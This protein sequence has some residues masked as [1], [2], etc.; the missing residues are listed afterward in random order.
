VLVGFLAARQAGDDGQENLRVVTQQAVPNFQIRPRANAA[1]VMVSLG[2]FS[3]WCRRTR[4]CHE[5]ALDVYD[6]AR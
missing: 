1:Y 2:E 6:C 4:R 5:T 3:P